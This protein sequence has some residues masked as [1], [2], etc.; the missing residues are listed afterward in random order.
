MNYQLVYDATWLC[1][2]C[3]GLTP[4]SELI[5]APGRTVVDLAYGLITEGVIPEGPMIEPKDLRCPSCG[6][7]DMVLPEKITG[8]P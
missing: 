7:A 6:G 8:E 4:G 3:E 5:V 1:R 2:Q